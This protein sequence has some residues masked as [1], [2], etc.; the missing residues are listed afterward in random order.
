MRYYSNFCK[1]VIYWILAVLCASSPTALALIIEADSPLGNSTA[2][3]DTNTGLNWL[4]LSV[5]F[6]QS[7]DEVSAE[8]RKGARYEGFRYATTNEVSVLLASL[9]LQFTTNENK[10][11]TQFQL[12]EHFLVMM[13][14]PSGIRCCDAATIRPVYGL[15]ST[16]ADSPNPGDPAS[17]FWA[18]FLQ[19]TSNGYPG[20]YKAAW[21]EPQST[22]VRSDSIPAPF[23][24]SWLIRDVPEPSSL[25]LLIFGLLSLFSSCRVRLRKHAIL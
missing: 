11:Q 13:A 8:F 17:F 15:T 2:F 22:R 5:T 10:S 3:V 19:T 9:G 14:V 16:I 18:S 7:F 1:T 25:L 4:D 20:F 21:V 6:N 24:G 23:I 12:L